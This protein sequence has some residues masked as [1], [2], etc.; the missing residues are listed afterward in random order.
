M[1]GI[2]VVVN[3]AL[4]LEL[5]LKAMLTLE[6]T[7]FRWIHDLEKLFLKLSPQTQRTLIRRHKKW[8]KHE[9]LA[10]LIADGTKTD[11][12]TLLNLG[13]CSFDRFRYRYENPTDGTIWGLDPC[14]SL[15]RNMVLRKLNIEPHPSFVE[16]YRDPLGR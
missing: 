3:A 10:R 9:T 11:L 6:R 2:P 7:K 5:Y 14:L 15:V 1:A 16:L 4:A 13:R 12:L 8:E